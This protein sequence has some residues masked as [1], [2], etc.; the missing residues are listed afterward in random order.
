MV[1]DTSAIAAILFDEPDAERIEAAIADTPLRLISAGTL[2]ECSI[3]VEARY[4]EDGGRELDLLLFKANLQIAPVTAEQVEIARAA[5]RRFGK[6]RHP[7]G[8]NF[9][10]CFSYALAISR[11]EPLL[12]KGDD[13][14]RTDVLAALRR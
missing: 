12:F 5:F 11:G 2:L 1:I 10:D 8:L 13:F 14:A 9:G 7:A 3:V 6:G 4:G